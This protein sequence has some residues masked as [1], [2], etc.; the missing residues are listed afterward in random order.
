LEGSK[1]K[2]ILG[3]KS[4]GDPISI[5]GQWYMLVIPAIVGSIK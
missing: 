3:K 5:N 2:A 4:L 1:L